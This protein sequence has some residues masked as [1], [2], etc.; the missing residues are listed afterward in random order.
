M[1]VYAENY[2]IEVHDQRSLDIF[3]NVKKSFPSTEQF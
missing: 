3:K 1:R 2:L